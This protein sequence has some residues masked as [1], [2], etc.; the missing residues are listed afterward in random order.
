M[1]VKATSLNEFNNTALRN[2]CITGHAAILAKIQPRNG[3]PNA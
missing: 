3:M 2:A 1:C